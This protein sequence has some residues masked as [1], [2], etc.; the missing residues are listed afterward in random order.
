MRMQFFKGEREGGGG[1]G[2]SQYRHDIGFEN[3]DIGLTPP[4]IVT[5]RK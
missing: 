1:G 5:F 2:L 3:W 4:P